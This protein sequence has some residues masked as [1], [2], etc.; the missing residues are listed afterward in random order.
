ME[1]S[2]NATFAKPTTALAQMPVSLVSGSAQAI[3]WTEKRNHKSFVRTLSTRLGFSI[4]DETVLI[5]DTVEKE[6]YAAL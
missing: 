1:H 6:V 4:G 2:A 5:I 3:R